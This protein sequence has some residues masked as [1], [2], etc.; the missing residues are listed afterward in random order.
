LLDCYGAEFFHKL[1]A[2]GHKANQ[3]M[4]MPRHNHMSTMAHFN[5]EEDLLGREICEFFRRYSS[6]APL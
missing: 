3:F 5:T 6:P 4:T 1:R 2:C